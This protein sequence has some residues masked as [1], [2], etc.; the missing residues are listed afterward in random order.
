MG[1]VR[2]II[3]RWMSSARYILALISAVVFPMIT[4]S[5]IKAFLSLQGIIPVQYFEA[6]KTGDSYNIGVLAI[7][8]LDKLNSLTLD[9][10]MRSVL[11]G[12]IMQSIVV[13]SLI[14]NIQADSNSGFIKLNITK[15]VKRGK[16]YLNYMLASVIAALPI[17]V[18]S[19]ISTFVVCNI[20]GIGH[21][22]DAGTVR[23]TILSQLI[24][25]LCLA[26][27]A[28]VVILLFQNSKMILL[29]LAAILTVPTISHYVYIFTGGRLSLD[30]AII[31][32]NLL[33]SCYMSSGQL[34]LSIA[35]AVITLVVFAVAGLFVFRKKNY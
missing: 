17:I 15:G 1:K 14:S 33:G 2:F 18:L 32:C 27:S 22:N 4:I 19:L 34:L 21:M 10:F 35:V 20:R 28:V 31:V 23:V 6:F 25:I 24:M 30:R 7:S 8:S 3:L 12:T 9:D 26:L 5:V 16:I 29:I 13:V 11:S